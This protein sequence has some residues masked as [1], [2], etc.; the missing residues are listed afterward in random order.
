MIGAGDLSLI[1]A[2]L[3]WNALFGLG[4]GFS[5]YF[6]LPLAFVFFFFFILFPLY[7]ALGFAERKLAADL[8]ARV[9]PNRT[10]GGGALQMVADTLKLG[11]KRVAYSDSSLNPRWFALQNAILYSSFAFAPFGTALVFLDSEMGA[12]LPF[13]C[14]AGVFICPLFASEGVAELETEI[15]AHRQAFLWVSAWVPALVAVTVS[16]ARAGSARWSAILSS[17]AHGPFHWAIFSSPFEFAAFFVFVFAGLVAL[18]LPPFHAL[19]RGVRHRSGARLGLFG[20]NSFYATFMWC[21]LAA[22]LF[23]GGQA[24]HDPVDV[25]F[26]V[27]LFQLGA[28]LLKAGAIYLLLRVVAKALPQLRQDQ[29]TELCWRVLTPVSALCLVGELVWLQ[30]FS[31]GAG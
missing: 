1:T 18:Q 12:F 17:Q 31:G 9:G 2:S 30:V 7:F 27:A 28:S 23:L 22:G 11:A 24:P 8:Q 15:M 10:P 5:A 4:E 19:D 25:T 16:V 13:A 6:A 21:L 29:M 3:G 14:F 20:L 26:A